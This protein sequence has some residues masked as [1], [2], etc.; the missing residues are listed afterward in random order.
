MRVL[1][2]GGAGYIG[3]H[4][5]LALIEAGHHVI[6]VDDLS[7]SSAEAIV[8]VQ[9]LSGVVVPLLVADVRDE[10]ALRAFVQAHAPVDAVIH[11]AGAKAVGDSVADPIR[12]YDVNLGSAIAVLKVMAAERIST[13]VFSS[14]ATV[15]GQS[16]SLPLSESSPTGIDLANP[17]GK[18]KRII[19]AILED[20]A[21]AD[22][23][24]AAIA[25]RYFNPVGAH[26][27][28]LIGEDPS[29]VPNNLMPYVARV[30]VGALERVGIFGD[31]YATPDGTG[32]RDYV[33]VLDLAAGHV[34]ALEH[35]RAGYD[36]FNL[37]TGV[38]VSV[39][40]L[41]AAFERAAGRSIP[42]EVLGRRPGDV[43]ASY[44]DPSKAGRELDWIASRTIDDACRDTWR[45][46][47][48]NP[49]GYGSAADRRA[50]A[51]GSQLGA[52]A[53]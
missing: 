45:W 34:A 53:A 33:H 4:T 8:R 15:Y 24:L 18:T 28:G 17:Y 13:I 47:S 40:E 25:L 43:A 37:G 20:A 36:V 26:P 5:A 38:P 16:E 48:R 27:S 39:L 7:N 22:P 29:G 42:T 30:A 3:A 46:Q 10:P 31:D 9:Q 23:G 1:L 14:S 35:A 19:E 11:F 44:C 50:A 52:G 2:S 49:A 6:V 51:S 12:Y 41:I 21:S 32:Q